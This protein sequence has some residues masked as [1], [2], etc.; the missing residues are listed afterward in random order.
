MYLYENS[1]CRNGEE[2]E[3]KEEGLPD[4]T[5]QD[6]ILTSLGQ[7]NLSAGGVGRLDARGQSEFVT[8]EVGKEYRIV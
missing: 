2:P 5:A 3:L 7:Q 4:S 6:Y 8:L 1:A